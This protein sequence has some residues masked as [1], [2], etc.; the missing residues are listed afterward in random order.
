MVESGDESVCVAG[1]FNAAGNV[2][3]YMAPAV[4]NRKARVFDVTSDSMVVVVVVV[5]GSTGA[6]MACD[7]SRSCL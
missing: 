7:G 2:R 6:A 5:D 3:A 4:M 1:E